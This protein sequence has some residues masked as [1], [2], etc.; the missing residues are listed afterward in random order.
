VFAVRDFAEIEDQYM[1]LCTAKGTIKK[2]SL[3]AFSSPRRGGIIAINLDGEDEL[4]SACRSDGNQDV[5]IA[6]RQGKAIHFPEGEVRPMGRAAG[7][8]RGIRLADSDVVVGME[9]LS[10]GSDVLTVTT[11]GYGKRT[12]LADYRIQKRGGQGII[13]MRTNDRI[14]AVIGVLQVVPGQEL[15]LITDYGKVLR[16][17]VGGISSMGRATQGVRIMAIAEDESIVSIAR[18]ADAE[19]TED[20]ETAEGTPSPDAA[21]V[22]D[23]A[24]VPEAVE[25]ADAADA[26]ESAD[27]ADSE[28]E[29]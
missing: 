14:G 17:E 18:L 4:I 19:I 29:S 15:M 20:A 8:V 27:E 2:T 1:I 21:E 3:K 23:V 16:C 9:V 26:V 6:S 28:D 25:P 5:V 10:P 7:G 24:E 13:T 11:R 12:P 22:T